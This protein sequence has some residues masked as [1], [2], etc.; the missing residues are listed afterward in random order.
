MSVIFL[1]ET[2]DWDTLTLWDYLCEGNVPSHWKDFFHREDVQKSLQNV[3]E[4][5]MKKSKGCTIYP[6]INKVFRAFNTPLNKV[7]V[8]VL[9]QDPYFNPGSAVGICMS[10]PPNVPINPT[11]R[12]VYTELENEGYTP[13]RDGSL[14]HWADQGCLMLNTA[15]SVEKGTAE[16]HLHIW[17]DFSE[18][19]LD[20]IGKNTRDVA[21]LLM[22][23]KALAFEKYALEK[24]GHNVFVTSHPSPLSAYK[25]FRG[26]PA[27]IGSGVFNKIDKF[28]GKRKILW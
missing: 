15:L 27:F 20:Y 12:N 7:K 28:L 1:D 18:K 13:R 10:V 11:L 25:G 2:Y 19:V 22:G 23:A 24:N 6:P 4:G 17:Y 14:I 21:W 3:S 8:V 16:S 5:I 9:L 26:Y